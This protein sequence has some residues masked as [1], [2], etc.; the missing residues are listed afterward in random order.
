MPQLSDFK[1]FNVN[2]IIFSDVKSN[3]KPVNH[4]RIYLKVDYGYTSK[5]IYFKMA[6]C[7]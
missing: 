5:W 7:V 4:K 2:D 3:N 1:T 6:A